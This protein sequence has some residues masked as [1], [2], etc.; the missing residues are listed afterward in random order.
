MARCQI[1]EEERFAEYLDRL[2]EVV[3]HRDRLP[4]LRAY[5]TGL[6]LPGERKSVEPMAAKI[7][8]RHVRARQQSM[9]HFVA[10]ASWSDEAVL[11]VA[12]NYAL[13]QMER[14]GPVGAW[15]V[16]DT[17]IPKKGRHSVGIARQYCGILGKQD[18]CQVVVSISIANATISVPSFYRLYL[19]E[20]WAT[21][22][23]RRVDAGV[24][25]E[26]RFQPKWR[27]ALV[28]IDHLL[29]EQLPPAPVVADAGYGDT[30]EFRDQ[31]TARGLGYV[32]GI[33]AE[34]T[35]WPPG[36]APLP[37]KPWRVATAGHRRGCSALPSTAPWRRASS[38]WGCRG[39]RGAQCVG[40]RGHAA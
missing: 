34:T 33:K 28:G 3:G 39:G 24:P 26:L 16:D 31:L 38:L 4:S 36:Q 1:S 7:D 2:S 8:P 22:Q 19:P 23:K 30:T 27:I 17:G 6:L 25:E 10:N 15:I 40:A 21:D 37:P 13:E 12:V 9:P 35:I 18:N 14:H 32:V 29:A 20:P 11:R 5:L